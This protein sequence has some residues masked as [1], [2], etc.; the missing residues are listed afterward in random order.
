MED[1]LFNKGAVLDE[2]KKIE[3]EIQEETLK[4]NVDADKITKLY[5]KQLWTGILMTQAPNWGVF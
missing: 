5:N 1:T 4:E 3:D 2:L